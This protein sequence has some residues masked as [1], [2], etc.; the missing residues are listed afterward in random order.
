MMRRSHLIN[1]AVLT[2]S[3]VPT[4]ASIGET[5]AAIVAIGPDDWLKAH[6]TGQR[7]SAHTLRCEN[8]SSATSGALIAWL[9]SRQRRANLIWANLTVDEKDSKKA[10]SR[11]D[12][13]MVSLCVELHFLRFLPSCIFNLIQLFEYIYSTNHP[14]YLL[15]RMTSF[16]EP[17]GVQSSL[18]FSPT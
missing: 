5:E 12:E 16:D 18:L 14:F 3:A 1:T 17:K 6:F 13:V 10:Q 15:P 4:R 9:T 7:S 11:V 8:I 2:G